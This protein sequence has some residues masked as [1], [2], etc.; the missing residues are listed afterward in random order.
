[1]LSVRKAFSSFQSYHVAGE[2][3]C[4]SELK[5]RLVVSTMEAP[6]YRLRWVFEGILITYVGVKGDSSGISC[7]AM[8]KCL[9]LARLNYL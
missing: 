2:F 4:E 1:M 7:I 8:L 9:W 5:Q 3:P 6:L